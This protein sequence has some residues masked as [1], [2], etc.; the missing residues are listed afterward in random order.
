MGQA[1][2]WEKQC[3]D[4]RGVESKMWPGGRKDDNSEYKRKKRTNWGQGKGRAAE[5]MSGR[6]AKRNVGQE[7]RVG[8]GRNEGLKKERVRVWTRGMRPWWR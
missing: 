6:M 4:K 3:R 1:G 2:K 7:G 5:V 8:G